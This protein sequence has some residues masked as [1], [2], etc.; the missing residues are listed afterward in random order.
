LHTHSLPDTASGKHFIE[1]GGA[2]LEKF[3]YPIDSSNPRN[4]TNPSN[5]SNPSNSKMKELKRIA[6]QYGIA[7]IYV[8]GSRANEI[9]A[10]VSGEKSEYSYPDSDVDISIEPI[11]GKT[12]IAKEKVQVAIEFE[13]LF[14]VPRVDLIILSEAPPFLALEV[15][16]G[17]LL[18]CKT[19]DEQAEHELFILRRAGDLAYF[20]RRRRETVLGS[21]F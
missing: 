15:I 20:E 7:E 2:K 13:D 8:F 1:I 5:P 16:K 9:S 4:P 17:K 10:R 19:P 6:D 12:L 21:A 18:Y 14:Q 3:I 11:P